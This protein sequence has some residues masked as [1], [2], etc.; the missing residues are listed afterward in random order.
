MRLRTLPLGVAPVV[1]G[2][3]LAH[4]RAVYGPS[5]GVGLAD[6]A[7]S[8]VRLHA[9]GRF[10]AIAALCLAVAVFLQIAANFANDYSDGIRG[11]DTD[12]ESRAAAYPRL[13][14]SGVSPRAV[15]AAAAGNAAIAC[16]AGVGVAAVSGHWW[17]LLVGACCVAAGWFYVGGR[18]PYGYHGFGELAVFVFFGLVAVLGTVYALTGTT[19]FID[20]Y[21]AATVGFIAVAVLSVNNLRDCEAD[22]AAGKRTG[23]VMLGEDRGRICLELLLGLVIVLVLLPWCNLAVAG[24]TEIFGSV[25]WF[26]LSLLGTILTIELLVRAIVAVHHKEW[27]RALPTASFSALALALSIVFLAL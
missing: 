22:E 19:M 8:A 27:R 12:R 16:L 18:H 26:M 13:V 10:W 5:A 6:L 25:V 17:L 23:M 15:L 2:A 14:A 21:F 20:W 24:F 11:T 7:P 1:I 3:S 4:A 9:E